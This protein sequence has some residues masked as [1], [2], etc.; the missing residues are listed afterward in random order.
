MNAKMILAGLGALALIGSLAACGPAASSPAPASALSIIQSDGYTASNQAI[1]VPSSA[2]DSFSS[3]ADGLDSNGN[4]EYVA[5]LM[6]LAATDT[7]S[8]WESNL[9]ASDQVAYPGATATLNGDVIRIDIPAEDNPT[10]GSGSP[11]APAP[12]PAPVD[13]L[14]TDPAG[15]TCSSLDSAG[16]CP[17]DDPSTQ[18][19]APTLTQ[20]ASTQ[21]AAPAP[22]A[23]TPTVAPVLPVFACG[24]SPN[25]GGDVGPTAGDGTG[26][27]SAVVK[28]AV[29]NSQGNI[30]QT[31]TLTLTS[32]ETEAN[33][34]T[35]WNEV[36][37]PNGEP[38]AASCTVTVESAS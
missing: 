21:A 1:G 37:D 24:I 25:A 38:G 16:Y 22:V 20:A 6:T 10:I 28:V 33:G 35:P 15:T 36:I 11:S 13:T 14:A 18:T 8:E 34:G 7:G 31:L 9:L 29:L 32:S 26:Y 2:V 3:L 23:S 30:I 19:A 27:T 4:G 5:V 17:G 12:A